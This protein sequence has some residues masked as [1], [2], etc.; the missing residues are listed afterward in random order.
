MLY[1]TILELDELSEGEVRRC[2]VGRREVLVFRQSGEVTA[3]KARCT[4]LPW[5]LPAKQE[6]GVVTCPFRGARFDLGTGERVRGPASREWQGRMP[7]GVGTVAAAFVPGKSSCANLES[8]SARVV[9][10]KV[11]VEVE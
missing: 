11:Q 1:T 5:R 7:L 10:G 4:H 8:Y 9:D 3:V 2:R 6:D